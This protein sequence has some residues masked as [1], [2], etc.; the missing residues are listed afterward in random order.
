MP[1]DLTDDKSTL[2]QVMAWCR[3]ATSHYLSQC[4]PRS[5][6]PYGVTRLQWVNLAIFKLVSR[7]DTLHVSCV[8]V[9][10][11]MP[12]ETSLMVTQCWFRKW[13]GA[14]SR[15]AITWANVGPDPCHHIASLGH[16]KSTKQC[17]REYASIFIQKCTFEDDVPEIYSKLSWSSLSYNG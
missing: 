11:L 15:Q 8:I 5:L 4:W 2:V 3:Q 13:L 10:K 6:S 9:I 17:S 16:N 14:I 12:K 1:L 7:I